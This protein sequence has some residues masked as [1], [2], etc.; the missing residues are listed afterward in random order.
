MPTGLLL[1]RLPSFQTEVAEVH[2]N[3]LLLTSTR[4]LDHRATHAVEENTKDDENNSEHLPPV[5]SDQAA[6]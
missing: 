6:H 2:T 4:G 3:A 1:I 5:L